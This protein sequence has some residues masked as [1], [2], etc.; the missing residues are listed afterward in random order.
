MPRSPFEWRPGRVRSWSA[1]VDISTVG[2][3]NATQRIV[4][5]LLDPVK[6]REREGGTRKCSVGSTWPRKAL[7]LAKCRRQYSWKSFTSLLLTR[8]GIPGD[9]NFDY[10]QIQWQGL[11]PRHLPVLRS[12]TA[13]KVRRYDRP[14]SAL[15]LAE[16]IYTARTHA[17]E[18]ARWDGS[19]FLV[20]LVRCSSSFWEMIHDVTFQCFSTILIILCSRLF[21]LSLLLRL[22]FPVSIREIWHLPIYLIDRKQVG[23]R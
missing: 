5:A 12:K 6:R 8:G 22:F 1:G 15:V 13:R 9:V 7:A 18:I 16:D 17:A 20:S 14:S 4:F 23:I 21:L 2:R 10:S 11:W 3:A 19:F